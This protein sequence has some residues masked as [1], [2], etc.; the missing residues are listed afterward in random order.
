MRDFLMG[1][2]AYTLTVDNIF[3]QEMRNDY[4]T[5]YTQYRDVYILSL[6]FLKIIDSALKFSK[7]DLIN[8]YEFFKENDNLEKILLKKAIYPNGETL[9][10]YNTSNFDLENLVNNKYNIYENFKEYMGCFNSDVKTVFKNY[11]FD[12]MIEFLYQNDMLF[13]MII[14]LNQIELNERKFNSFNHLKEAYESFLHEFY[15]YKSLTESVPVDIQYNAVSPYFLT[16]LLLTDVK[17]KKRKEVDVFSPLCGDGFL[18]FETKRLINEINPNCRVNLY[19]KEKDITEYAICISKCIINKENTS[20]ILKVPDTLSALV[21][22]TEKKFDFIISDFLIDDLNIDTPK[23]NSLNPLQIFS[24]IYQKMNNSCKLVVSLSSES[25]SF[26]NPVI[27]TAIYKDKL[28]T[29]FSLNVF[30]DFANGMILVLNANKSK[31]RRGK[32]LLIDEYDKYSTQSA[33]SMSDLAKSFFNDLL[34]RYENFKEDSNSLTI[35]NAEIKNDIVLERLHERDKGFWDIDDRLKLNPFLD[36]EYEINQIDTDFKEFFLGNFIYNFNFN[37]MFYS[38]KRINI[39]SPVPYEYLGNL[40]SLDDRYDM[41]EII[42]DKEDTE[43]FLIPGYKKQHKEKVMFFNSELDD[44]S[45][46]GHILARVT[47]DKVLDEYIYYYINSIKGQE[48]VRFITRGQNILRADDLS[49]IRIPVPDIETQ[50]EIV[51]AVKK[52]NEFFDSVDMLKNQFQNN[53]LDYEHILDDIKEFQGEVEFS[54]EDYKFTKMNRNWRH[55]YDELLWPLAITY[56]SATKGGFE[57]V[58]KANAYLKLF[59]FVAAFNSIILISA[60]PEDTYGE[61]NREIWNSKDSMYFEM[62]FGKWSYITKNLSE[63]YRHYD[64]ITALDK[65]LFLEVSKKQLVDIIFKANGDRN[66]EAHSAI[67]NVY[68]AEE[69]IEELDPYLYN[70]FEILKAYSGLKLYYVTGNYTKIDEKIQHRVIIL[71]GPCAQPIY[72]DVFFNQELDEKCLYL[73][74]SKNNNLLKIKDNLMK[75]EAV[76]RYK[77]EWALFLFNGTCRDHETGEIYAKYKCYQR[78]QDDKLVKIDN[79]RQDILSK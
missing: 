33:E 9:G 20:N 35:S 44:N 28:D 66:I 42:F 12:D 15:K 18:L 64:F 58:E 41:G 45:S 34:N 31:K 49:F 17:L 51:N 16:K 59:E 78:K 69:V 22:L 3:H 54:E 27:T 23:R 39:N 56:L 53:I 79:I 36:L 10:F 67:T 19:G 2:F 71:N 8:E 50:K 61:I 77:R 62:T 25:M 1:L 48:D 32:F 52:S 76:D 60:I 6:G 68:E 38:K 57:T 73:Y 29:I 74:D 13:D 63:V 72:D 47:S 37:N 26:I 70:L 11:E 5:N 14:C 30:N 65:N 24:N 46:L 7:K 21:P 4:K 43:L 40:M 55:L 75:F